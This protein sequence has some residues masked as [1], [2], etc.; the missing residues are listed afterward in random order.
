MQIS[1][2]GDK[3]R[4]INTIP[5]N[6]ERIMEFEHNNNRFITEESKEKHLEYIHDENCLHLSIFSIER[7]RLIGHILIIGIEDP[8]KVLEFRRIA[9]NE[10]SKG[11]GR[12]TLK[13]LKHLAFNLI[14]CHRLWLDVYEDNARAI[15]LYESEG[16]V[17]EGLLR[18]KIK[19]NETYRSMWLYSMLEQEYVSDE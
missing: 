15:K 5:E 9:I 12:D 4:F 17:R 16:F 8:N 2:S 18:E 7:E 3:I 13:L 10:K 6:I 11:Y 19:S 1:L 14:K